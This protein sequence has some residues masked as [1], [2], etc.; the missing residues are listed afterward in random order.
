MYDPASETTSLLTVEMARARKEH[1]VVAYKEKLFVFGGSDVDGGSLNS[2]EMYSPN[3][4]RFVS[5]APMRLGRSD[6]A[7]CRAGSKVYVIGG[8]TNYGQ[9]D[10]VE[11][12]DLNADTW[13]WGIPLPREVTQPLHAC[14]V[15]SKLDELS[16]VYKK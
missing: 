7:C 9:T 1:K 15:S 6:F 3:A 16:F 10:T 5:M 13:D 12:Y 8:F 4:N 11:I 2:V 14:D